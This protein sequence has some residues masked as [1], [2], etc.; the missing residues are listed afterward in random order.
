KKPRTMR[1]RL[2]GRLPPGTQ[3]KDII[4]RLIGEIGVAAGNGHAVEYAGEVI[5][6]LPIEGRF[7]ICNMS[8]EFGARFGLIAPDDTAFAYLADRPYTP[9]G[10]QW[11]AALA[12]WRAL[13]SDDDALF[14]RE[15]VVD[16]SGL[17]PQVTWGNTP[18][19]VLPIDGHIPD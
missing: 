1:I 12:D 7:T 17:A 5:R 13:A 18:E 6:D 2:D 8:V 10:A 19:A 3:G 15:I 11:D 14:D 16:L 4:L 9:K